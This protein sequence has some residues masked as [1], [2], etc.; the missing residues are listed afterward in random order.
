MG[1]ISDAYAE[2]AKLGAVQLLFQ[3]LLG[4]AENAVGK[5]RPVGELAVT[6]ANAE[7]PILQL[8]DDGASG[9]V[10]RLEPLGDLFR[11]GAQHRQQV[12][13]R[14]IIL[15]EGGLRRNAFCLVLHMHH[16]IVLAARQVIE[17]P[18]HD[19]VALH[20]RCLFHGLQLADG[21]DPILLQRRCKGLAD[22]P[23]HRNRLVAQEGQRFRLADHRE[24]AR[25]F[26]IGGDLGE[27]FAIG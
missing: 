25:L 22:T 16:S 8:Q 13:C 26:Q 6:G 12:G 4:C 27:E 2:Q 14:R 17:P 24:T 18:A 5:L 7:L 23:D 11:Q 10:G 20:Q 21:A 9:E 3:H 15:V 19:A 1:E